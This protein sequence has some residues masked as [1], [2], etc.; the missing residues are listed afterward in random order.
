MAFC[1]YTIC[2]NYIYCERTLHPVNK[3]QA[4]ELSLELLAFSLL[5]ILFLAIFI[6]TSKINLF[7]VKANHFLPDYLE[8]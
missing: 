2:S 1:Q 3:F 5:M 4:H 6:V 8:C 7:S